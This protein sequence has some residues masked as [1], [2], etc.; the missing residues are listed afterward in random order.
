MNL[1]SGKKL[2]FI[3]GG[4]EQESTIKWARERGVLNYV[5]DINEN[6]VGFRYAEKRLVCDIRNREKI[7][8]FAEENSVDGV[9]SVCLESTMHTVAFIVDTLGF[10]GL[11]KEETENVTNKYRMR[12]LFEGAGLPVPRYRLI[13]GEL[14]DS[15]NFPEF[16]GPW[17]VKPIDNAGS[18]GVKYI[19]DRRDIKKAYIDAM[20]YSRRKEVLVE[21]FI[22]GNEISVEG[23]VIDG[24]LIVETLSDKNRTELPYLLDLDLTFPSKYPDNIQKEAINQVQMAV[25]AL[26]VQIG[27]IHAELMV[28]EDGKVFIIEVAGR[29]PGSKVY[30]EI[31]PYV[32]GIYPGRLQV[33]SALNCMVKKIDKNEHLK[34][35]TLY[36]FTSQVRSR[37][38]R[39]IGLNE[40]EKL[41]GVFE[42][43]MYVKEGDVVEKCINGEQ[44]IGQII[45]MSET[46]EKA[47]EAQKKVLEIVKIEFEK[48]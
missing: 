15:E 33:L 27:P 3:G 21:E 43:R 20:D 40:A 18:R 41:P 4:F 22:P 13:D 39:I 19:K 29:G 25:E 28:T 7:L 14:L 30:T 37:I 6:A 16:D 5:V 11:G 42:C 38:K 10:P 47:I 12:I 31:I 24:Q 46:L 2:L 45:T 36:F 35:A 17:V 23:Y 26:G 48:I 9:T 1:L 44:R 32:S 8:E 34:G